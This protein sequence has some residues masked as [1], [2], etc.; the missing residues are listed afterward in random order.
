[1]T[2]TNKQERYFR[3]YF[4]THSFKYAQ[5][6]LELVNEYHVGIRKDGS[7]ERSHLF[8]VLGFAIA[9]F[10][11]TLSKYDFEK[12]IVASALHDL[13]EDY[14]VKINFKTLKEVL[15][16]DYIRS[17]K[18]VTKWSTFKKV[19]K[20]Y[21]HYHGNI[22]KDFISI[23]VKATD[24][25]HNLNSCTEVFTS[26]K[27]LDYIKETERYIIPNLKKLRKDKKELYSSVTF[28]IYNLKNQMSQLRYVI[29]LEKRIAELK[30]FNKLQTEMITEK[31]AK[32]IKLTDDINECYKNQDDLNRV[33]SYLS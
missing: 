26:S 4:E 28:L 16:K 20:D 18:K 31:E 29:D 10:E 1:M 7:E 13:V 14:A 24:R 12:L 17:I 21:E 27:K 33:N 15:P 5:F 6:A 2:R 19:Q 32:I 8:E 11:N 23:I 25:L 30:E 9:N 3:K 22:S